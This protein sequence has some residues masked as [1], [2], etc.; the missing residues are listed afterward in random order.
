M[1]REI[2]PLWWVLDFRTFTALATNYI[3]VSIATG[4]H[5]A[6]AALLLKYPESG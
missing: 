2:F 6:L 5:P 4:G 1:E 3:Y